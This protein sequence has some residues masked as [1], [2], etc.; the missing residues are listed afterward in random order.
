MSSLP[1]LNHRALDSSGDPISGA[2]YNFYVAGTST[3]QDTYSDSALSSANA[4]PVVA[5]GNGLF[6]A[7]YLDPTKTYKCVLTDANDNTIESRDNV[8]APLIA[9]D[10]YHTRLKEGVNSPLQHGAAGDGSTNDDTEIALAITNHKGVIDLLNRTYR[11]D[12][13][14]NLTDNLLLKN[15]TID[16]SN[17]S[18]TGDCI[19]FEG[20]NSAAVN[21]FSSISAGDIS[22]VATDH[23]LSVGDYVLVYDTS[24][25]GV[26]REVVTVSGSTVGVDKPFEVAY[27]TG[28]GAAM[29]GFS[30]LRQ[31]LT[32]ENVTFKGF[33]S[34]TPDNILRIF[35]AKNVRLRN[36]R[37]EAIYNAGLEVENCVDVR[38]E[39]CEAFPTAATAGTDYGFTFAG[40]RDLTV[41]N[42]KVRGYFQNGIRVFDGSASNTTGILT[43]QAYIEK[44][45]IGGAALTSATHGIFIDTNV[46][47]LYIE[48]NEISDHCSTAGIFLQGG[49]NSEKNI[50]VRKNELWR[51]DGI[52]IRGVGAVIEDNHIWEAGEDGITA[53]GGAR[54]H[55]NRIFS[56][57]EKG[58]EITSGQ[59][60]D[61]LWIQDNY[62]YQSAGISIDVAI[63]AASDNIHV[64]RNICDD[65]QH[66]T[67]T[68]TIS[69]VASAGVMSNFTCNDN[70]IISV[71]ADSIINISGASGAVATQGQI[72]RNVMDGT[73]QNG[74][75]AVTHFDSVQIN[76]NNIGSNSGAGAGIL[77]T[78]TT[79]AGYIEASGNIIENPVTYGI[80]L[81]NSSGD[82]S[83]V[84]MTRNQIRASGNSTIRLDGDIDS[85][86][87][88]SNILLKDDDNEENISLNGI[89]G[90]N[91]ITD[92]TITGNH[93]TN[94]DYGVGGANCDR[95]ITDGNTFTG[96]SSGNV[97]T[98][99]PVGTNLTAGDAQ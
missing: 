39:D 57:A 64:D 5:D 18:A 15:G 23:G 55:R 47:Q 56:P 77:I 7:I 24:N 50:Y 89:D 46:E 36:V 4:N 34:G 52:G 54:I 38:V 94:G 97:D 69:V 85:V 21:L 74:A 41:I 45:R 13:K 92:V 86:V 19:G 63:G 10:S 42:N 61:G 6:G 51:I 59:D 78:N 79:G 70:Q 80:H 90:S 16:F 44:N 82:I 3:R 81:N 22:F 26:I 84:L 76:D 93:L 14:L 31:N 66:N 48:K 96:M 32:I 68:D 11:C 67:S 87:L 73:S 49:Y 17:F 28:S 8:T 9:A 91:E 71:T 72:C 40:V 65:P 58:I 35:G 95:I 20:T 62:I 88:S 27:A 30:T 98:V 33:T 12:T 99:T 25:P 43:E 2:K 75:I 53:E 1:Y 29:R 60:G 37:F 83:Q